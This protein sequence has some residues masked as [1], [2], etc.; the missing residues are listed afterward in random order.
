[1][2][3]ANWTWRPAQE[4]SWTSDFRRLGLGS[5]LLTRYYSLQ[6]HQGGAWWIICGKSARKREHVSLLSRLLSLT[7]RAFFLQCL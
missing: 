3:G 7:P 5:K 1:M 4:S 6:I 2:H